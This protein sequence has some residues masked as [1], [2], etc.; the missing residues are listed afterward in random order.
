MTTPQK[1]PVATKK[2][3]KP[4]ECVVFE[5][6]KTLNDVSTWMEKSS[7]GSNKEEMIKKL[8]T[9]EAKEIQGLY[10]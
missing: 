3:S 2:G 1:T 8:A 10:D 9:A 6:I 5:D 4:I 7:T